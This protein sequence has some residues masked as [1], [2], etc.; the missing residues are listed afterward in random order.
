MVTALPW[1]V[2]EAGLCLWG[3]ALDCGAAGVQLAEEQLLLPK[4]Q[5][6]SFAVIFLGKEKTW[7][8]SGERLPG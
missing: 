7:D 8:S 3:P 4:P 1:S 2:A 6:W 5:I